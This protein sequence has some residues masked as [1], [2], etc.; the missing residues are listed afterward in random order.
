MSNFLGIPLPVV[1]L[2]CLGIA[3]A[4]YY[5]VWPKPNPGQVRTYSLFVTTLLVSRKRDQEKP[6]A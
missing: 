3:A 4:Y 2:I 5:F 6:H 1:S